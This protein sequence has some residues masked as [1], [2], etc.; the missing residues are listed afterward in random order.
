MATATELDNI[1]Q[2]RKLVVIKHAKIIGRM[3]FLKRWTH[4]KLIALNFAV[5]NHDNEEVKRTNRS[6]LIN[7]LCI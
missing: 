1:L 4:L 6:W 2:Y 3:C 5:I 7:S